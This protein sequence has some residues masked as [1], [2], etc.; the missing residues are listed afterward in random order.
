M[1]ALVRKYVPNGTYGF[2]T[3]ESTEVFFHLWVFDPLG[4]PPPIVGEVVEVVL[5]GTKLEKG[6]PRADK[7]VRVTQPEL[8]TGTILKFDPIRGYGF[9]TCNQG[10]TYYLHKSEVTGTDTLLPGMPVKFYV[11]TKSDEAQK[12][13]ACHVTLGR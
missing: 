6:L 11:G 5:C 7:V 9:V 4:G 8:K 12:P 1:L 2:L 3:T 13:R 10:D